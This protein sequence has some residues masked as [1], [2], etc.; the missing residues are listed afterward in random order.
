MMEA[1]H[2]YE[3]TVNPS[4]GEGMMVLFGAPLAQEDHAMRAC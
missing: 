3:D 4:M 1:V 2:R